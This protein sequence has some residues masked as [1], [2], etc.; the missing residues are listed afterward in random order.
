M[1]ISHSRDSLISEAIILQ[2]SSLLMVHRLAYGWPLRRNI[3]EPAP[4]H[5]SRLQFP[6]RWGKQA[7]LDTECSN[8]P[9][10]ACRVW[11]TLRKV[12]P[13]DN[14]SLNIQEGGRWTNSIYRRYRS[15]V[16]EN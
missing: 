4:K 8:L 16:I 15:I 7:V 6:R 9:R 11:C 5:N 3:F 2:A 10:P 1:Y 12:R 13:Q 14:V